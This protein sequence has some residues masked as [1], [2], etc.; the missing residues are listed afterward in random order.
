MNLIFF[1]FSAP[2]WVS[3]KRRRLG[4]S[5][6]YRSYDHTFIDRIK[7]HVFRRAKKYQSFSLALF[8]VSFKREFTWKG[9]RMEH[10]SWKV[11]FFIRKDWFLNKLVLCIF[12][13]CLLFLFLTDNNWYSFRYKDS[14]RMEQMKLYGVLV[15]Y[16]GALLAHE[17]VARPLLRLLEDCAAEILPAELERRLVTLLNRLCVALMQNMTLLDLFFHPTDPGRN[18]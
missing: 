17:P 14:V 8:G 5:Q 12:D 1:Y 11:R 9:L 4:S 10:P 18:A 13:I 3:H 2:K 7:M 16:N 6:S 15:S